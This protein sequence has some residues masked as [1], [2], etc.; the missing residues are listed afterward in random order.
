MPLGRIHRGFTIG[1]CLPIADVQDLVH[2]LSTLAEQGQESSAI[3]LSRLY[4]RV[5]GEQDGMYILEQ[6]GA[7]GSIERVLEEDII[8]PKARYLLMVSHLIILSIC[9]LTFSFQG[10]DG[11]VPPGACRCL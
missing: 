3:A 5:A 8:T 9:L 6:L 11:L 7:S 2:Q 1:W 10:C 4:R